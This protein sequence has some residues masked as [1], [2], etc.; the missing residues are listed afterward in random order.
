MS[1]EKDNASNALESMGLKKINPPCAIAL[2]LARE[3]KLVSLANLSSSSTFK[4]KLEGKG[5]AL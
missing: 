3:E 5:S 4:K 1:P 2:S